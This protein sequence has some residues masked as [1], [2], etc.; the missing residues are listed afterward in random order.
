M[1]RIENEK[2]NFN[3]EKNYNNSKKNKK[4][5]N[6]SKKY[7][8]KK[9]ETPIVEAVEEPV[10]IIAND[11]TVEAKT[12]EIKKEIVTEVIEEKI[13]EEPIVADKEEVVKAISKAKRRKSSTVR[14][15]FS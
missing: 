8:E 9:E 7:E 3:S 10:A 1:E 11:E 12:E 4:Y 5:E 13:A 14:K 15:I 6:Y 2:N